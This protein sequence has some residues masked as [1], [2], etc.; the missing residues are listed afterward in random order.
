LFLDVAGRLDERESGLFFAYQNTWPIHD[1]F[2][3]QYAEARPLVW[4]LVQEMAKVS[5]EA[6]SMF[7]I[8]LSPTHMNAAT[9]DPPWRVG[10]FLRE[11]QQD[12]DAAGVPFVNCVHQY[13]DEGGND[14]FLA[15]KGA[16]HLNAEGNVLIARTTWRWLQEHCPAAGRKTK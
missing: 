10:S 11:Y 15:G 3:G 7:V 9:D 6:D 1:A 14:R 2:S 4:A 13:F 8:T 12:A 16:H 5:R